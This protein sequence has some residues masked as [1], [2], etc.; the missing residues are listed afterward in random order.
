VR[1]TLLRPSATHSVLSGSQQQ[2]V[3]ALRDFLPAA[4]LDDPTGW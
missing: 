1:S 4:A 3:A 2:A